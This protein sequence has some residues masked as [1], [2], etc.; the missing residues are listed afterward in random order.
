M[1]AR[2]MVASDMPWYAPCSDRTSVRPVTRMAS[3]IA[4]STASP[5]PARTATFV[6]PSGIS[7]ASRV[8]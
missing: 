2:L 3:L 4:A 1:P 5:P 6:R 8:Q 7:P